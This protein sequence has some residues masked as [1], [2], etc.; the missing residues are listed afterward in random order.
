MTGTTAN[1]DLL[2]PTRIS[3]MQWLILFLCMLASMIEGFDIVIISYT[4]PAISQDLAVSPGELGVVFSAGVFGMA[5]G[6]M[7]L[8][9]V[10]DRLGRR[11]VVSA[12][13]LVA[14]L[15][16]LAVAFSGSVSELVIWRVVA[17]LALG[18]L[19]ATLPALVGEFSPLRYRTLVIAVLLAAANFGGFAGGLIVAEV[20]A[21]QGWRPIFLYT[22]ALTVVTALLVQFLV[23]ESLAFVMRRHREA[24]LE[25][26]NR[27]LAYIG[28]GQVTELPVLPDA[29]KTESA[30]VKSLLTHGRGATTWLLWSA[31]FLSF[32]TVYFISSW[33]PKVLIGAGLSQQA[34]IQGTTALPAGAIFGN[35][36]I[37][38]LATWWPLKRVL[39]AAFI[40]GGG[41]MAVLSGIHESIA[42]MPFYLIWLMLLVTGSAMFGA[43]GNLYNVAMIVYPVQVRGTG[44]G[45]AAG[46]GR[47]G[48]VLSPSLAGVMIAAG[49]SMPSLFFYFAI[50]AFAAGACVAFIRMRELD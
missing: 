3:P 42:S 12:A 20:I 48:A 15:G 30:T 32:L 10:S 27:T 45:W 11:I 23:P 28:Q 34:A 8:G 37:G 21:E 26:V 14:G 2:H 16:T 35:I 17:G 29:Q 43:F 7:F 47:A 25:K 39:L 36:L 1:N 6:A 13:L 31:F 33:M 24:V 46:L 9:G 50:P 41:C 22:G 44:L 19:V 38:W 5:F 40:V 4:A 49:F 18:A